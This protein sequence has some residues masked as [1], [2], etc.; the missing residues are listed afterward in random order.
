MGAASLV[1]AICGLVLAFL[2]LGW[3]AANYVLTGGRIRVELHVGA[4]DLRGIVSG[5]PGQ[6]EQ[7]WFEGL[8]AQGYTAPMVAV[9]VANVGRQPVTVERW[10]LEGPPASYAP[11]S[12]SD[13]VERHNKDLDGS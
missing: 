7:G 10:S 2:S 13:E 12:N 9:R 8:A 5:R 4:R 11:G 1:V 6:L 3:Q